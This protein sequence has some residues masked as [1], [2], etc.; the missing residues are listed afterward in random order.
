MAA[1]GSRQSAHISSFVYDDNLTCQR[2][3]FLRTLQQIFRLMCP[4]GDLWT[5]C[6]DSTSQPIETKASR[7][8]VIDSVALRLTGREIGLL[9]VRKL[10]AMLVDQG[11]K[12]RSRTEVEA[13]LPANLNS[14]RRSRVKP[15]LQRSVLSYQK[16]ATVIT[17]STTLFMRP[18]SFKVLPSWLRYL[19]LGCTGSIVLNRQFMIE[20]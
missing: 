5:S 1:E 10:A 9:G 20:D 4:A 6:G 11:G 16:L 14:M 15:I 17:G 7:R 8:E 12:G 13:K 19:Y 3:K 18:F 2:T